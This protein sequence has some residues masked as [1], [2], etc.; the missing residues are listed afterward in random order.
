M[1]LLACINIPYVAL[2]IIM[3]RHVSWRDLPAAV[4]TEEKPLGRITSANKPAR[5]AGVRPG[6]RYASALGICPQLRVEPVSEEARAE[7]V[8]HVV[9]IL[10]GFSPQVEASRAD[11]ALFWVNAGGMD[12]L[13]ASPAT[14]AGSVE[15]ALERARLVSAVAVGWSRFGSY[16][17]AKRRTGVTVLTSESQEHALAQRAPVS[18]LPL[19]H[20]VIERLLQLGMTT[21]RDFVRFSP[22]SLRRRFGREVEALHR[23]ARGEAELPLQPVAE[24]VPLRLARRLSY[25]ERTAQGVLHHL[26][27][28]LG[29][30]FVAAQ[31]RAS[32]VAEVSAELQLE[33]GSLQTEVVRSAGATSSRALYEKLLRLRLEATELTQPV[34]ALAMEARVVEAGREQGDLFRHT[35]RRDPATARAAVALVQAEL[36]NDAVQTATLSCRHLPEEQ[37]EWRPVTSLSAP[38]PE[39]ETEQLRPSLVRRILR[40]PVAQG[41]SSCGPR[42]AVTPTGAVGP[43]VHR[44]TTGWWREPT[45]REYRYVETA[46]GRL[47]WGYIDQ[48]TGRW[49]IQG[50]VE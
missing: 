6:M 20:Q 38:H 25:A 1:A 41:S 45:A 15:T 43:T 49:R 11:A 44:I 37:F 50:A 27:E 3:R 5:A 10:H 29:A 17:A 8:N 26:Y 42:T 23:F 35:P 4:V 7:I 39:M 34:T 48:R 14:W 2:Q 24:A 28:L 12:R 31:D 32:L 21:I 46:A 18:I 47:L 36:G 9:E 30:L 19:E 33:D 40:Q 13:F 22:G 16:A